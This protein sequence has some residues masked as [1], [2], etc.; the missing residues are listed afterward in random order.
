MKESQNITDKKSIKVKCSFCGR[1]IECP[2]E[3]M[4]SKKHMCYAC[5]QNPGELAK[6]ADLKQ[7]HVDIPLDKMDELFPENMTNALLK[8]IFPDVWKERKKEFKAMPKKN[9]AEEMF[10]AGAYIAIQ[11]MLA[12]MKNMNA[13]EKH[14]EK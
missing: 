7:V 9:L 12:A 13:D 3:M 2:E 4:H 11:Q 10:S 6:N 1:E 14:H 5:F 8:E